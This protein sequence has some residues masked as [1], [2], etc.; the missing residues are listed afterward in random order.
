MVGFGE[1]GAPHRLF[2]E[3]AHESED[4]HDV[5]IADPTAIVVV[6]D[7][8]A[9]VKSGLDAQGL[10]IELE[11]PEGIQFVGFETG[12]EPDLLGF[13]AQDVAA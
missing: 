12:D 2:G 1:L 9:L 5:G 13:V 6:G 4:E 11:P 8:E 3:A 10:A 7:V